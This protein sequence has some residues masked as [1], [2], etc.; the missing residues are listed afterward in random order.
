MPAE[1]LHSQSF[2]YATYRDYV[3]ALAAIDNAYQKLHHFLTSTPNVD[4]DSQTYETT[5]VPKDGSVTIIDRVHGRLE[6]QEF[7][8]AAALSEKSVSKCIT[9]L[10]QCPDGADIR[11]I[12][13]SY[14]RDQFTGKYTGVDTDLLDAVGKKFRVHPEVLMWHFGS[15][16]G[17]DRRLFPFAKSPIPAALSNH[18]FC[19]L[20]NDHSLFSCCVFSSAVAE[21]PKTRESDC[22]FLSRHVFS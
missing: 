19:H 20:Q 7:S 16:Y 3:S 4:V 8:M 18:T 11:I 6:L 10:N 17:L 9:A 1:S 21:D 22:Y 13:F 2:P 5:Q 12:L 15:D 14:H